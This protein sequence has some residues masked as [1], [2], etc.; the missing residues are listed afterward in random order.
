MGNPSSLAR[1]DIGVAQLIEEGG[2]AMVHIR[3]GT[4]RRDSALEEKRGGRERGTDR[5]RQMEIARGGQTSTTLQHQHTHTHTHTHTHRHTLLT[6]KG[7]D[8][9]SD[10]PCLARHDIGVAQLIEQ[11]SLAVVHVPHNGHHGWAGR[12]LR[13]LLLIHRSVKKLRKSAT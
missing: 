3:A 9:L 10:P 4:E 7:G 2:L 6:G 13:H 8:V 5:W 11:G 12:P 1:H